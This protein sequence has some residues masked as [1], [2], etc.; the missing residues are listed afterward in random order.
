VRRGGVVA[1]PSSAHELNPMARLV[2]AH[3]TYPSLL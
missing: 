2:E 3:V 1:L